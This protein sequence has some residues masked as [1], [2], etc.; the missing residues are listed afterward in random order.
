MLLQS[1][2]TFPSFVSFDLSIDISKMPIIFS[3][4]HRSHNGIRSTYSHSIIA[5]K[6]CVKLRFVRSLSQASVPSAEMFHILQLRESI[7]E[8]AELWQGT[9]PHHRHIFDTV[10]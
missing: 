2:Q 9:S 7:S 8:Q 10:T 6:S 3:T 1:R 4:T 5:K